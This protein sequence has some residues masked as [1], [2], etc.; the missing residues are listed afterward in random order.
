MRSGAFVAVWPLAKCSL[1]ALP[2]SCALAICQ[3]LNRP[4]GP[5]SCAFSQK[6]NS[7]NAGQLV[8]RYSALFPSIDADALAL[9]NRVLSR[10][11]GGYLA[12]GALLRPTGGYLWTKTQGGTNRRNTA[13]TSADRNTK[14][15]LTLTIAGCNKVVCSGFI[16]H[17]E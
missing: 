6:R 15:T 1:R 10:H 4:P 3:R 14:I 7:H 8:P 2:C 16:M 5:T 11:T 13:K 12:T 9:A 17:T